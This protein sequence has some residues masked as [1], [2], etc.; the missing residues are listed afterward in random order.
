VLEEV[1]AKMVQDGVLTATRTAKGLSFAAQ[2]KQAPEAG[3]VVVRRPF[4][5]YAGTPA[6]TPIALK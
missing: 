2:A 6:E 3:S 5:R 4:L 1:L